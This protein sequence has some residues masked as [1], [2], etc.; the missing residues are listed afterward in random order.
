VASQ[1]QIITNEYEQQ[2][3]DQDLIV[4][5]IGATVLLASRLSEDVIDQGLVRDLASFVPSA[6]SRRV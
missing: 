5:A 3:P 6:A 1:A 4:A 2:E